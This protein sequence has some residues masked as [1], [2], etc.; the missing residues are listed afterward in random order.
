MA[1]IASALH[2]LYAGRFI[3]LVWIGAFIGAE[4]F[5][6]LFLKVGELKFD[7]CKNGCA[8]KVCCI[9]TSD[10]S[11]IQLGFAVA[12]KAENKMRTVK[13]NHVFIINLPFFSQMLR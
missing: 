12:K 11:R 1:G 6:E 13:N 10:I 9:R 4:L 8:A 3:S 7:N 5:D 2:S